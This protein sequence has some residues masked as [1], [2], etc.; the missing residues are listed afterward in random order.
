MKRYAFVFESKDVAYYFPSE[1]LQLGPL[2]LGSKSYNL[3]LPLGRQKM[4]KYML[5][6][7]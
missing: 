2:H 7:G 3:N 6:K 4:P 1:T 5:L